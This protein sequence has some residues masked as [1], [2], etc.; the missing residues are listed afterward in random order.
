LPPSRWDEGALAGW[1]G[2][3]LGHGS[4]LDVPVAELPDYYGRLGCPQGATDVVLI[5]DALCVVPQALRERFLAW[6][7]EVQARVISLVLNREAGDLAGLSDEVHLVEALT[8]DGEAA[9]RALSL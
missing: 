5:T 2:A 9:G 7:R 4:S 3:F 8:P 1:L 6:K